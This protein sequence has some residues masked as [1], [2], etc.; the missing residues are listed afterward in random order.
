MSK[1]RAVSSSS[2]RAISSLTAFM[3]G[4]FPP[5]PSDKTVPIPWQAFPFAVDNEARLLTL[6]P[7]ACSRY[8][9]E[10]LE[11]VANL[12]S[13]PTIQSWM[14]EDKELRDRI[15]EFVGR[16]LNTFKDVFLA[17]EVLRTESF[18]NSTI[19][20]W[21]LKDTHHM[22]RYAMRYAD[23]Y[24][25]T[26][27]MTK[28]RGGPMITEVVDNMFAKWQNNSTAHNII[29]FSAH[30]FTL[31]GMVLVLDVRSQ[32]PLYKYG[33]TIA[34]EMHQTVDGNEP[35]V[36]VYYNSY[37]SNPKLRFQ[38]FVPGCG[39]PCTLTRFSAIVGKYI[40]RD[41]DDMCQL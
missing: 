16:P 33:D 4:F 11:T 35:E 20:E 12:D 14:T 40:V 28:V 36:Q 21:V 27:Y 13:D 8:L 39:S 29:V 22:E 30:D 19:P 26:E 9:K 23:A 31:H 38:L 18:L 5:P 32:V 2:D 34:I 1:I 37:T 25:E 17:G 6:E 7:T 10:Y 24:H 15:G 3:A 41:F